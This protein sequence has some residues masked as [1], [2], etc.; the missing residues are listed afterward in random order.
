MKALLG[1]LVFLLCLQPCL[2]AV[3]DLGR[4]GA[5]YPIAEK[6][7][8]EEIEEAASKVDWSGVFN[9]E[10]WQER[11]KAFR[12]QD[13]PKLPR[14]PRGR[15]RTV[16]LTWT[17]PFDIP[18]VDPS[19][20]TAGVLYPRGYTFNPLDYVTY[21]R[22]LVVVDGADPEQL[23][24]FE[25]SPYAKRADVLLL[26][27]DGSWYELSQRLGRPVFYA[28][29]EVVDRFKL[30]YVPSVIRQKGR[31]MEV[32][33]IDVQKELEAF[34][35]NSGTAGRVSPDRRNGRTR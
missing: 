4:W 9:P 34:K 19:G 17:L 10:R 5:V 12:P 3:R 14:A 2:G 31:L 6:D 30:Q 13:V 20:R 27:T 23:E 16:D 32:R 8:L 7:A 18:K 29:R 26:L 28:L 21:P 24:W 15:V 25:R 11:I 22:T 35:K 33:E 1:I